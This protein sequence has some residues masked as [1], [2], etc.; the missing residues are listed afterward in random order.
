MTVADASVANPLA[1][2][3]AIHASSAENAVAVGN[4]GVIAKTENGTTWTRVT[5]FV[6]VGVNLNCVWVKS[7]TEWWV[8]TSA[9]TL[10]YTL[11]GGETWTQKSFAGSGSGSVRDIWFATD[12]VVYMAHSTST[13]VGRMLRSTNG[14]YDW[15]VMPEGVGSMPDNDRIN[16]VA[17]CS[18]NP[19]IVVGVGLAGNGTDG[20]IVVGS[21]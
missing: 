2:Y 8:G 16:A 9:G 13:P 10:Y 18:E 7:A 19:D 15:V 3:N 20:F 14:G 1:T 5:P 11:D 12:S 4:G 21:D 6:G 17:A